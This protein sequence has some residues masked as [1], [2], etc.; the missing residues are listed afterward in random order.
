MNVIRLLVLTM[1]FILSTSWADLVDRPAESW[2]EYDLLAE[3]IVLSMDVETDIQHSK[4]GLSEGYGNLA[5][6]EL[7]E[8]LKMPST[9]NQLAV[10]VPTYWLNDGVRL[11]AFPFATHFASGMPVKVS[12]KWNQDQSWIVLR[13]VLSDEQWARYEE[14][15]RAGQN[16]VI[17]TPL[18]DHDHALQEQFQQVQMALEKI[19]EYGK[20]FDNGT[21]TREE[22]QRLTE[23]L[24]QII[25]QPI[26]WEIK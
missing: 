23:P 10:I 2:T 22:Y 18:S 3:V 26:T 13:E 16:D 14:Q 20:Q 11:P 12:G 9:S 15:I 24:E 7:R 6:L 25:Q 5:S 19:E 4:A 1:I 21:L 17:A 8:S